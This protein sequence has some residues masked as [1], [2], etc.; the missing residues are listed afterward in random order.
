MKAVRE[1]GDRGLRARFYLGATQKLRPEQKALLPD[2]LAHGAEA[3]GFRGEVWT[4]A[5]VGA[6]IAHKLGVVYHRAHVSRLSKELAWTPQKPPARAAQRDEIKIA[7]WRQEVWPGLVRQARRERRIIVFIDEAGFYLLPGLVRTYAP[8]GEA[9]VL[10]RFETRDHSSV[11]SGVTTG[12][13]LYTLTRTRPLTSWESVSFLP[14]L[15]RCLGRRLLVIWDG[16]PIGPT[17]SRLF[18]RTGA[19]ALSIWEGFRL[20]RRT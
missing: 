11:M 2:Y 16:S 18:W 14:H 17:R 10:R 4:C 19:A 8:C 5:R 15:S 7:Q 9:P 3:Y 13:Q 1:H 20:M 6:V 12:G